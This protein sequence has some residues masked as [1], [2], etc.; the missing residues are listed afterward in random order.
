MTTSSQ[1]KTFKAGNLEG[2]KMQLEMSSKEFPCCFYGSYSERG[3]ELLG[4]ERVEGS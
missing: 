1:G 4:I 2:L 3:L